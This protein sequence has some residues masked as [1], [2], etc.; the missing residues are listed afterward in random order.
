MAALLLTLAACHLVSTADYASILSVPQ[1][2]WD[3]FNETVSGRLR[4]GIPMLAPCYT[5]YNG[6][7]QTVN[8]KECDVLQQGRGDPLF[9][10]DYFGGYTTSNWAGCAAT[11]E[12]CAMRYTVPDLVTPVTRECRQGSVPWMY[13]EARSVEDVQKTLQFA[14][15]QGLRLVVKNTGHDY[16]GRSS[17]PGSLGLWVHNI[18]PPIELTRAFVPDGCSGAVGDVITF[19]AGQQFKGVYEFADAH[20]YRAVGG[21]SNGVGV[22]GGWLAGGGHSMLS[23]E[24]GL[25]VDNVQQIKAV[26]PNG[27]Y[28]T[29]NRCQNQD[30]FFALRGGGGGTFAVVTEVGYL[31]HPKKPIQFAQISINSRDEGIVAEFFAIVV[32]NSERWAAEGWGGYINPAWVGGLSAV[33]FGTALL[34]LAEAQKSLQPLIDFANRPI[35]TGT[36]GNASVITGDYHTIL[37]GVIAGSSGAILPS[38]GFTFTSRLVPRETFIGDNQQ[39]LAFTLHRILDTAQQ[40]DATASSSL[41]MYAVTPS[42]YSRTLPESDLPGGPG[43][44]S[45]TPAWCNSLWHVL[46][47][48]QFEGTTTDPGVVERIWQSTHDMLDPLRKITPTGG[49]YQNEADPFEP[50][51]IRSFWG[52]EN[53]AR[54]LRIKKEVDP[55][56][57]LTVHKGV[58]W[59]KTDIRYNCYPDIKV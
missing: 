52:E 48:R 18:Q 44:P 10:S 59:E 50:D 7:E 49:A 16:L 15:E 42:L 38:S 57:L 2:H 13:V 54:L 19:G 41:M 21:T 33:T 9:V 47:I 1:T 20:G 53:Y 22:A 17:V 23:N 12:N 36:L 14:R 5:T 58:G 55:T 27:T 40:Q 26:L 3:R 37:Q 6:E 29:A 11:G 25:G 8:T 46:Y 43:A 28:F 4:H 51:H 24:L 35:E 45:V 56:N 31:V 32:A 34:D 30:L 39:Q